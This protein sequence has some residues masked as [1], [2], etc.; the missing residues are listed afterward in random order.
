MLDVLYVRGVLRVFGVLAS[1]CTK[2]CLNSTSALQNL[3]PSTK[4]ELS[5]DGA[6]PMGCSRMRL[7]KPVIAAVA[8]ALHCCEYVLTGPLNS[9]I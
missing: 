9:L 5:P 3:E 6:G 4:M 7:S 2:T 1:T 8:G